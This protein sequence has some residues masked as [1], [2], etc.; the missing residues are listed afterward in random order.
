M[1]IWLA[2]RVWW[3]VLTDGSF[4]NEAAQRLTGAEP[5][6]VQP[7][8]GERPARPAP[9]TSQPEPAR[10]EAITLLGALQ[11][12]ARLVDMVKEP[13]ENYSDAQVGAAARDVLRDCGNVL[14]RMFQLQPVVEQAEG[15]SLDV[16]AGFDA[17][18]Y[19]LTGKVEGEP[20]YQGKLVHHGWKASICKLPHWSGKAAA[21][22]VIAPVEVEVTTSTQSSGGNE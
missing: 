1:R 8:L 3:R 11:R 7:E 15:A 21:R 20:P 17:E 10:S 5:R 2:F 12:E 14:D 19:R 4:A 16:P 13:L 22:W 18:C 9:P 6:V